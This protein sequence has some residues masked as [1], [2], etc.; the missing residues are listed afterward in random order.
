MIP[1]KS[2]TTSA[3]ISYTMDKSWEGVQIYNNIMLNLSAHIRNVIKTA[4][5][6]M[7]ITEVNQLAR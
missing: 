2:G 6:R 5:E 7:P 3:T 4:Y 1:A